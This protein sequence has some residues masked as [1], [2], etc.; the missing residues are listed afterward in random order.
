[1]AMFTGPETPMITCPL[2]GETYTVEQAK[3]GMVRVNGLMICRRCANMP[4]IKSQISEY[5]ARAEADRL[6]LQRA[7]EHNK[8]EQEAEEYVSR[9]T[10]KL[11]RKHC[12]ECGVTT[13]KLKAVNGKLMCFHCA[14]PANR[15]AQG[16]IK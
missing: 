8:L 15:S 11:D 5:L 2:S 6:R 7:I 10:V 16:L 13:D 14:Q 3:V 9:T 1:M 4:D 12:A